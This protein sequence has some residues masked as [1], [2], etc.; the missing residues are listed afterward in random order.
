[1]YAPAQECRVIVTIEEEG[2]LPRYVTWRSRSGV[3]AIRRGA[4]KAYPG[5]VLQFGNSVW[6]T[7]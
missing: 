2:K 4:K 5:A 6:V 1:M 3:A 7:L